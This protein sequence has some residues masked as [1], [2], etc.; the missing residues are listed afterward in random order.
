ME[1]NTQSR[2]SS[3][4]KRFSLGVVTSVVKGMRSITS[5][6]ELSVALPYQYIHLYRHSIG[7]CLHGHVCTF[8]TFQKQD[9]YDRPTSVS[10]VLYNRHSVSGELYGRHSMSDVL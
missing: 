10:D 4:S 5:L 3:L 1:T 8:C 6:S 2:T 9:D 7:R